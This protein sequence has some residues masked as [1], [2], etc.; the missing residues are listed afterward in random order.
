MRM[1]TGATS[2]KENHPISNESATTGEKGL[3][4]ETGV[5]SS[6]AVALKASTSKRKSRGD[7]ATDP[8]SEPGK[9]YSIRRKP[10]ERIWRNQILNRVGGE[11]ARSTTNKPFPPFA[12]LITLYNEN[13]GETTEAK[14]RNSRTVTWTQK[15]L[16]I[17]IDI[18]LCRAVNDG[19]KQSPTH[20]VKTMEHPQRF[21][22]H[23]STSI[24]SAM[25]FEKLLNTERRAIDEWL[26]GLDSAQQ[27]DWRKQLVIAG[28]QSP[29]FKDFM[30]NQLKLE[31][32]NECTPTFSGQG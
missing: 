22:F 13:V 7:A 12:G 6:S 30:K 1:I 4:D 31:K 26:E 32:L 2:S 3:S 28:A 15:R 23:N 10:C 11:M 18:V 19:D 24:S 8:K 9:G 5:N 16:T 21:S 17:S 14:D 25:D 20:D 27:E 29:E